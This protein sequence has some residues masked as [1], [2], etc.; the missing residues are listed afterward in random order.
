MMEFTTGIKLKKHRAKLIIV[1]FKK[2]LKIT[3]VINGPKNLIAKPPMAANKRFEAG[4]ANATCIMPVLAFLKN[5]GSTGTGFAQPNPT[6]IIIKDPNGSK[7]ANGFNVNRP[8]FAAVLSPSL[9]AIYA[10]ENS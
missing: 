10:C 8:I 5:R 7:C 1:K 6:N 9:Y 2:T 4:P 3:S